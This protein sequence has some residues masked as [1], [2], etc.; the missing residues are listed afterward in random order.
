[1]ETIVILIVA[2]GISAAVV[3]WATMPPGGSILPKRSKPSRR[4]AEEA[5]LSFRETFQATGP[6]PTPFRPAPEDGFMA[7][8]E[9]APDD[10]R[11]PVLS[12]LRLALAIGLVAAIGVAILALL[13]LLVKLQVDKYLGGG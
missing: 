5:S 9:A 10:R 12:V 3:W 6:D 8:Q 13:G 2:A 4:Q 11:S 7:V 1:M